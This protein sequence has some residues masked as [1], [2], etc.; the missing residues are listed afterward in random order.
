MF[1]DNKKEKGSADP[2]GKQPNRN[3]IST[4]TK[5]KGDIVSEADFRIDGELEGNIKTSGKVVIGREGF[6]NGTIECIHADIEGSFSG[7][8]QVSDL[9]T[10]KSTAHIQGEVTTG[11]LSVEPGATFD[12]S[13]KMKPATDV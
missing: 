5:V 1:S 6:I 9:L 13:C 4:K 8:L 12:A 7:V 11:K 2:Y 10:L 3:R